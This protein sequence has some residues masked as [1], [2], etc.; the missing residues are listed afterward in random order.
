[1]TT[2][3]RLKAMLG[4]LLF[5]QAALMAQIEQQQK[6]LAAAQDALQKMCKQAQAAPAPQE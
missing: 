4:D 2:E 3:D 5:T 6:D 1:M